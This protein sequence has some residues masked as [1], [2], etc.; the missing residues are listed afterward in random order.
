MLVIPGF[1]EGYRSL[2]DKT[3][4]L[5][6]ETNEPTPDQMAAI[7][8]ALMKAGYMAFHTDM[9]T[10]AQLKG[11]TDIQV[12]FDNPGKTPGQRLRAVLYRNWE[13][14]NQGY[15]NFHDFYIVNMDKMIDHY[16]AKLD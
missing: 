4:K 10:D 5:V 13:K 1:L 3:L 8:A 9:F 12:E 6:F 14:E 11:I 15:K 16:K 7:Q 2:K